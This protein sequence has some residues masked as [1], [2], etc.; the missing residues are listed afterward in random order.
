M[1]GKI[2]D[3]RWLMALT[4]VGIVGATMTSIFQTGTHIPSAPADSH[5]RRLIQHGRL[6]LMT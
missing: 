3:G 5:G 4:Y 6:G 1:G 2:F